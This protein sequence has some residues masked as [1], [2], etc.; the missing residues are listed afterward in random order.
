MK[1]LY[2]RK[3]K[4]KLLNN[5]ELLHEIFEKWGNMYDKIYKK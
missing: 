2:K 3:P 5:T 4:E 1:T